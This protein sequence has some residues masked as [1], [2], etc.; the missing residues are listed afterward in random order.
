MSRFRDVYAPEEMPGYGA[1]GTP[2]RLTQIG[3]GS[4]GGEQANMQRAYSL[5]RFTLPKAVRLFEHVAA[6]IDHWE[7]MD[8]PYATWPF[9]DWMDFASV[10]LTKPQVVPTVTPFDQTFATG[11]GTTTEFQLTKTYSRGG[12]EHVR[13]IVLPVV[14]TIRIGVAGLEVL[15]TSS[16]ADW[17]VEREGGTVTFAS[18]P[19]DGA[20]IT[21]GGLFDLNVRFENDEALDLILQNFQIGAFGDLV[22]LEV[23]LC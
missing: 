10:K 16:P 21:W 19:A 13:R 8:G 23:P 4:S 9:R 20:A 11:D 2:R 17:E 5:R 12:Y 6:V 22:L 18:P 14:D 7:V 3:I 15:N 1:Y